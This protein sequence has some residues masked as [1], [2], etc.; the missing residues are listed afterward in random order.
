[1]TVLTGGEAIV[2]GLKAHGVDTIFGLPG[3][4]VYGLFD[5]F[6]QAK[7]NVI[8]ARHEQACGYMAFGYARASGKPGVFSVV[9]GP[10]ILNASAAMLTA[11]GCNEPVMCLTGQVPSDYLGKGRGHLHEMPDQLATLR[12]F[13]KWAERI[14][15]PADAPTKVARGFQEMMSGRRGPVALE[16]P[17]DVFTQRAETAAATTLEPFA[18]PSP[19]PDRIRA[20]AA[21]IKASKSPMIFVGAGAMDASDDILALAEMIDAPVVAFRSGRGIVSNAHELGLTMAAAYNLWP[22][23]DLMIGIGSRMELPTTFRW[24]F[25]P[26]GIKS[27][28]IDIDPVEFRRLAVDAP[29]VADATEGTRALVAAVSKAGYTKTSGR[30]ETIRAASAKAQKDIQAIQPQMAYLDILRDVLPGN[31]IVTDELSQVGFTSWFGFPVYQP[32]TF[33]TS[34]YQG[35]LGSGFPTALGAKVAQPDRP[36]VAITGDGGFMFAVQELATAVQF[37]IGVVTLVFNNNAYGNVRRDQLQVFDGRVVAADLVNPD[38]VKLAESFGVGAAR[39]TS[40]AEFRPA[41]EK[42]LADGGPYLI[43]VDVPRDSEVSPW[44]FIHPKKP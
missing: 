2:S 26:E 40:P 18:P 30:R 28:R 38:F 3:A 11:F 5:A 25:R 13:V 16:M 19:D 29:I 24:P 12:S 10:G 42:A 34:G 21:L 32:R 35:T 23:T 20:A 7:L 31:A 17:W 14:D 6:H 4:Q 33:I 36:V 22:Q 9:P 39:V 1:M 8:G 27:I 44:A 15:Y 37:K 41:L 43:A